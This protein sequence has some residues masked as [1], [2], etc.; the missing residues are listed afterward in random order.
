MTSS[1]RIKGVGDA[2][3]ENFESQNLA[4]AATINLRLQMI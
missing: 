1:F 3:L 4:G 2:V